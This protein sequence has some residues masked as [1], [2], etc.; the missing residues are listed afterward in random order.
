VCARC[1]H[2]SLLLVREMQFV[3]MVTIPEPRQFQTPTAF[4]VTYPYA[5]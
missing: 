4:M 2:S 5:A 3:P 1:Q